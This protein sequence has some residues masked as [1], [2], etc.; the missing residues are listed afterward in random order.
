MYVQGTKT[1]Q[2][3]FDNTTKGATLPV[4]I[5]ETI[6][7][8]VMHLWPNMHLQFMWGTDNSKQKHFCLI[9]RIHPRQR[10]QKIWKNYHTSQRVF[11]ISP[12]FFG[13]F[14]LPQA[15]KNQKKCQ[16]LLAAFLLSKMLQTIPKKHS[17]PKGI[18]S[19]PSFFFPKFWAKT[20]PAILKTIF[21]QSFC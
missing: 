8:D 10:H 2:K 9:S 7:C 4:C 15:F 16:K 1:I 19:P 20:E 18:L 13:F 14:E 12:D 6:C 21:C 11:S 5:F 17:R 3:T